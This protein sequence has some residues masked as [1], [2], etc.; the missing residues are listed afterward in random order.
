MEESE[1]RRFSVT[2]ESAV[3]VIRLSLPFMLDPIEVDRVIEAMLAEVTGKAARRWAMDLSEV[4]YMGSAMLGL[5]VN[6]RERI[7]AG[8]G[9]LVLF[10]M[11]PQLLEIFRT[12]CLERLFT[13]ARTREEALKVATR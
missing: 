2:E 9:K 7:R 3:S 4:A 12:C 13:I 10:G 8:G 6:V 11:A 1:K 5:M